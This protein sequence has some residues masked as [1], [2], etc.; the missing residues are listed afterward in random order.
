[1]VTLI[2]SIPPYWK[3]EQ[4]EFNER[5][6]DVNTVAGRKFLLSRSPITYVAHINKPLL[7]LQGEHDPRVKKFEAEQIVAQM[8]AKSLP[9]TYVLYH[10][11]GHGF[12]RSSNAISANAIIE[13]FLAQNLHGRFEPIGNDF[14]GANFSI[15]AGK[16]YIDGL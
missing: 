13:Q 5:V 1:L 10:D 14:A 2:Q 12:L 8:K 9:V 6:G 15:V 4:A 7:I 11:E 3:P 16:K